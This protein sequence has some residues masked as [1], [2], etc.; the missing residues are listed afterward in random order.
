MYEM[1]AIILRFQCV[2]QW[3][4]TCDCT[5]NLAVMDANNLKSVPAQDANNLKSVPAWCRQAT[6]H[7]PRH[8]WSGY[9]SFYSSTM[10]R[11]Q[12]NDPIKRNLGHCQSHCMGHR[13][14]QIDTGLMI[15]FHSGIKIKSKRGPIY[16]LCCKYNVCRNSQQALSA[17]LIIIFFI[18]FRVI[19]LEL[20]HVCI[21]ASEGFPL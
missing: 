13:Q 8:C 14:H 4:V 10:V 19:S 20:G 18:C 7:H 1:L 2:N 6:C 12:W 16:S 17:L 9:F 15:T 3:L 5:R 21:M 11:E